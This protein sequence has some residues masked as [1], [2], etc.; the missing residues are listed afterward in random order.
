TVAPAGTGVL[1]AGPRARM[2]SPSTMT[3]ASGMTPPLPSI[4]RPKRMAVTSAA[5]APSEATANPAAQNTVTHRTAAGTQAGRVIAG[6]LCYLPRS[7][8][9]R[10]RSAEP[11]KIVRRDRRRRRDLLRG[12][13]RGV[14]RPPRP[15]RR[16]QVHDDPLRRRRPSSGLRRGAPRRRGRPDAALGAS[17]DRRRAAADRAL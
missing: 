11:Q 13:A 16:R 7:D 15:E 6:S 1:D 17:Q 5:D 9:A 14:F 12:G 2:R 8:H 10:D 3:T 4:R